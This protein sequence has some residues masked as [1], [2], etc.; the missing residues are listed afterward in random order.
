MAHVHASVPVS[1]GNHH[2]NWD[3]ALNAALARASE[4]GRKGEFD[5]TVEFS[6]TIKVTNPGRILAYNAT[7][8]DP[9]TP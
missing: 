6:A 1:A 3:A 8:I 9:T 4:L 7:L 2:E 5:V